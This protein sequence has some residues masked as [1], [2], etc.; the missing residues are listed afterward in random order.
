MSSYSVRIRLYAR[1][2]ALTTLLLF[3]FESYMHVVLQRH[4]HKLVKLVDDTP[5]SEGSCDH[6]FA[7]VKVDSGV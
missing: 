5:L 4:K 1:T 2:C 7:R 3:P 6:F